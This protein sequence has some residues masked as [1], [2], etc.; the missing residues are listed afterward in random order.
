[1]VI[2]I[3]IETNEKTVVITAIPID[4][5]VDTTISQALITNDTNP[6]LTIVPITASNTFTVYIL[7]IPIC[8]LN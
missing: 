5:T 2:I 1:M 7:F 8:L 4:N 3:A 6:M